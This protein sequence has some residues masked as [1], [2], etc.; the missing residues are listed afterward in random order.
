MHELKSIQKM[1]YKIL[2]RRR[3]FLADDAS[4]LS[5]ARFGEAVE[6]GEVLCARYLQKSYD[7]GAHPA[8]FF[9]NGSQGLPP[10]DPNLSQPLGTH[11]SVRLTRSVRRR[12]ASF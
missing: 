5:D 10:C 6:L 3:G 12:A 1:G 7:A 9:A 8:S 11:C 4:A 2:L